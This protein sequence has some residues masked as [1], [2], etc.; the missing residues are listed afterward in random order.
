LRKSR[1]IQSVGTVGDGFFIT[2]YILADSDLILQDLADALTNQGV[3]NG[4]DLVKERRLR[5]G[6]C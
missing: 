5:K 4:T 1:Q 2:A 3:I 6:N